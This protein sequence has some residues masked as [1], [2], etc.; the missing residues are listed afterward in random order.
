MV[1]HVKDAGT[2]WT[3]R[4]FARRR[5]V[6][7]TAAI[8]LTVQEADLYQQVRSNAASARIQPILDEVRSMMASSVSDGF[9]SDKG[10]M[11]EMWGEEK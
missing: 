2:D 7:I 6:G 8:Q 1:L 11:D 3:V 9:E 10:F 5:G 4:D